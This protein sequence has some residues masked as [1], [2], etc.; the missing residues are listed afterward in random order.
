[1]FHSGIQALQINQPASGQKVVYQAVNVTAGQNYLASGWIRTNAITA[2]GGASISISWRNSSG[3]GI[4][5]SF[6]GTQVGTTNWTQYSL[7]TTAPVG[8]VTA[9][10]SLGVIWGS[11]GTGYFDDLIFQ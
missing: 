1:M 5:Q 4:G 10:F 11:S 6:V 2:G 9:R 7:N 8:A 3:V